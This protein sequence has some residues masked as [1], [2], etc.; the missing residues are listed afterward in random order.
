M[1]AGR[2]ISRARLPALCE[3]PFD[4]MRRRCT[5]PPQGAKPLGK[6]CCLS[7]VKI[8]SGFDSTCVAGDT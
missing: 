1:R 8:L 7:F 5:A 6:V 2:D 3:N 4:Q